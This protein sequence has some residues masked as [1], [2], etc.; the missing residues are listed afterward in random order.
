MAR[1][2]GWD[3]GV[4]DRLNNHE[5]LRRSE[6]IADAGF[7]RAELLGPA[8]L[9]PDQ[10]MQDSYEI[11]TYGSTPG[12]NARLAGAWATQGVAV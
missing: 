6:L 4:I 12:Q 2:N 10:W 8:A 5:Q 3:P 7:H 11:V 9:I 1:L